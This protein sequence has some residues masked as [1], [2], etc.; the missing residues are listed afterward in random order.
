MAEEFSKGRLP[1]VPDENFPS[2]KSRIVT[3]IRIAGADVRFAIRNA[4]NIDLLTYQPDRA[5]YLAVWTG[6]RTLD[7]FSVPE[8]LRREWTELLTKAKPG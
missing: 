7:V 8:A 2:I 1:R 6:E 4:D 3:L 5:I